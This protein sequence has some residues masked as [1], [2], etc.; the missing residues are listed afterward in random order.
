MKRNYLIILAVVVIVMLVA[1]AAMAWPK[2]SSSGNNTN[3]IPA[4]VTVH[5]TSGL[6]FSPSAVT[7]K[8]G[9]NV[10]WIND[11]GITHTVVSDNSSDPFSSGL[12]AASHSYTHEFN[13]VGVFDYHC[14]IHPSMVAKV[15]VTA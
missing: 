2:P 13:K 8:A 11:A 5:I 4:G 6:T 7:I 3:E 10:T 9:E 15:T 12:L 1:I 14:S